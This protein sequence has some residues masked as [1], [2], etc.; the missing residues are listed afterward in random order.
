M[1]LGLSD[2]RR[3]YYERYGNSNKANQIL[4]KDTQIQG[5][6]YTPA[7]QYVGGAALVVVINIV[8][9]AIHSQN[10]NQLFPWVLES[11]SDWDFVIWGLAVVWMGL[12][13]YAL[14]K[15]FKLRKDAF[16]S[17]QELD[18]DLQSLIIDWDSGDRK[19][20]LKF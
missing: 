1:E 7:L 17:K 10:Y 9:I 2:E 16:K 8:I 14:F 20:R 6:W 12:V 11:P 5:S 18:N 15:A 13:L 3:N 19:I 4:E